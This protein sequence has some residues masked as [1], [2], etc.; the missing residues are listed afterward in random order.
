MIGSI[1]KYENKHDCTFK[2]GLFLVVINTKR[3]LLYP[4]VQRRLIRPLRQRDVETAVNW[5]I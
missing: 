5:R 4:P 3:T 2:I 1:L